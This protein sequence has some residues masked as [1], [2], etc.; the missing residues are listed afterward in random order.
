LTSKI[1]LHILKIPR[2][3]LLGNLPPVF[4]LGRPNLDTLSM[5]KER[6]A[7][8]IP[9]CGNGKRTGFKGVSRAT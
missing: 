3:G 2:R 8:K 9:E 1:L 4:P 6:L 7:K 5:L